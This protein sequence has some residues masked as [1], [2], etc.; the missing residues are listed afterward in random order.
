MSDPPLVH[1]AWARWSMQFD[2]LATRERLLLIAAAAALIWMTLDWSVGTRLRDERLQAR[3]QA[4]SL[5]AQ[6][7]AEDATVAQIVSAWMND[8]ARGHDAEL[9]RLRAALVHSH[10]ELET[11]TARLLRP[12]ILN[13]ALT[14]MLASAGSIEVRGVR[15][16][17]PAPLRIGG[18]D[19]GLNEHVVEIDMVASWPELLDYLERLESS[20]WRMVWHSLDFELKEWPRA[21]VRLAIASVSTAGARS[22]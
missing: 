16:L 5:T 20:P 14:P 10:A 4:A 12:E 21:Q 2:A 6:L 18:I 11:V 1:N 15:T 19:S 13:A 8:P 22:R 9:E 3:R 7:Q 17:A